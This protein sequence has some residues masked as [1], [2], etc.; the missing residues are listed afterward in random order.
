[1]GPTEASSR[2]TSRRTRTL[3]DLA[4]MREKGALNERRRVLAAVGEFQARL[5]NARRSVKEPRSELK[6]TQKRRCW[7]A[8][9]GPACDQLGVYAGRVGAY[10]P[11]WISCSNAWRLCRRSRIVLTGPR[12]PRARRPEAAHLDLPDPGAL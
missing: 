2:T 6:E 7:F 1:V 12:H 10:A 4:G 5:W 8:K 9:R 11:A 3:R